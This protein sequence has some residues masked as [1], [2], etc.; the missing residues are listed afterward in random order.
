MKPISLKVNGERITTQ[1]PPG[2]TLLDF[3]RDDLEL[4]GTKKGCDTGDCG[5]CTVL[6]DG[7]P[8]S[9]CLV[10]ALE[11]EGKEITTIEGLTRKG[12]LDPLQQVFVE[13]GAIQCGFCTPGMIITAK[14]FLDRHPQA[15]TAEIKQA[16][17]GNLCRCGA[18]QRI[19]DACLS[20]TQK[21]S[22]DDSKE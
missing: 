8:V 14:A 20:V 5:A 6:M 21:S 18:Y 17:S 7:W 16:L 13:Q 1:V 3:L 9:S 15:G 4:K 2:K 11:A 19:V 10:L 22:N 12:E